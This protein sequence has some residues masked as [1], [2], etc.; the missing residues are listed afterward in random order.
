MAEL[1]S[2][3]DGERLPAGHRAYVSCLFCDLR[4]FT[5]FAETAAPEELFELLREYHG[6]LG[7]LMPA[8]GGTLEHSYEVRGLRAA[9]VSTSR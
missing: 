7:E 2:S 6:A 5:S 8:Y 4:G 3:K 1:I 9:T